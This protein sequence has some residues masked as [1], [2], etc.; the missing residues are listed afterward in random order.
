MKFKSLLI[1]GLTDSAGVLVGGFAGLGAGKLL[2]L[3]INDPNLGNSALFGIALIVLGAAVGL[4]G[5][6]RLKLRRARDVSKTP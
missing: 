5:A 4:Q 2:G 3:N 1:E 6:R